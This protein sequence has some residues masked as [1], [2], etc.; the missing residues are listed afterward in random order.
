MEKYNFMLLFSILLVISYSQLSEKDSNLNPVRK[1]DVNTEETILLGFDNYTR[2]PSDKIEHNSSFDMY[3]LLKNWNKTII[4][5]IIKNHNLNDFYLDANVTYQEEDL[6][7]KPK[8]YHCEYSASKPHI[9]NYYQND[10]RYYITKYSCKSE[11]TEYIPKK[12]SINHN[13]TKIHLNGSDAITKVS[14]SAYYLGKDLVPLRNSILFDVKKEIESTS[15]TVEFPIL[16]NASFVSQSPNSFKIKGNLYLDFIYDYRYRYYEP[17]YEQKDFESE[18]IELLTMIK[19]NPS[20]IKCKG[21][22]AQDNTNDEEY[23]FLETKGG[24]SLSNI[25][26]DYTVFNFTKGKKNRTLIIDFKD[27]TDSTITDNSY[28]KKSSKGLSK[29]VICA[30]AI[31]TILLTLGVGALV[32]FLSRKPISPPQPIKNVMNNTVGIASS[33]VVVNQ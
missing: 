8:T 2:D 13:F 28:F 19:E 16:I 12:I 24:N 4:K 22:N 6:W 31:P 21:K 26:L 3:F 25:D 33:G 32:F 17:Y 30:I 29:G 18:N 27:G 15:D 5:D 20:K 23:Y 14:A 7:I 1:L 10:I 9:I 11:I